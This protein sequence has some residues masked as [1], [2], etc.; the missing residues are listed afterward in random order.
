MTTDVDVYFSDGCGRCPLGGTPECKVNRWRDGLLELRRI[1]L[2][3]GLTEE[4][5]WGSPCYTVDNKNVILIGAFKDNFVLSFLKGVLLND[6]HRILVKPGENSQSGRFIRFTHGAEVRDMKHILKSYI[7][8]AAEVEKAGLKI[9][10]K[11][12]P[13]SFPEELLT[14][15]DQLPDLKE[16]F[17]ALTPGKQRGYLLH[18]SAPKQSSTR[19]SRIEKC[20]GKIL[21]GEGFHD[22]PGKSARQAGAGNRGIGESGNRGILNNQ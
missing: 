9:T 12:D 16:A 3:C 5:K 21:A 19:I 4:C 20:I 2:E 8:E 6:P 11:S 7:Q 13:G 14:I 17:Y 22:A 18:F 15:M 1:L 10:F